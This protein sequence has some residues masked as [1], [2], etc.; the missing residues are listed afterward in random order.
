MMIMIIASFLFPRNMN[1]V[2]AELFDADLIFFSS[3]CFSEVFMENVLQSI[4]RYMMNM[5]MEGGD[6]VD[7]YDDGDDDDDDYTIATITHY[8]YYLHHHHHCR[9]HHHHHHIRSIDV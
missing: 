2:D 5:M 8:R 3:L 4:G 1:I 9:Y 6:V 7:D